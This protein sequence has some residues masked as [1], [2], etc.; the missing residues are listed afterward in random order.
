MAHQKPAVEILQKQFYPSGTDKTLTVTRSARHSK[1]P[2]CI[3]CQDKRRAYKV[4][5]SNPNSTP[6]QIAARHQ[7]IVAHAEMC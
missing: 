1:F 3:D 7:D 4:T 2:E 6:E 5:A